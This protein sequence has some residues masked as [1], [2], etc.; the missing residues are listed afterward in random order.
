MSMISK[1]FMDTIIHKYGGL[2]KTIPGLLPNPLGYFLYLTCRCNLKCD[3]CWQRKD[4]LRKPNWHNSC[5]DEMKA[6]DWINVVRNISRPSF[7]CLSGGEA[8]LSTAFAPVLKE[9]ANRRIPV[10]VNT[11]GHALHGKNLDLLFEHGV[12]NISVSLDGFADHHDKCRKKSGLFDSIVENIRELNSR[13]TS[14]SKPSLTIKTVLLDDNCEDLPAFRQFCEQELKAQCLNISFAKEGDHAQVSLKYCSDQAEILT[15]SQ[16]SLHQYSNQ[17]MMTKNLSKLLADNATSSCS[18]A[19]YP[20]M[21]SENEI[22]AALEAK[23]KNV[24]RSCRF[25]WAGV[26]VLPDGQV[27]P[28]LSIALGNVRDHAYS[29]SHVLKQGP[30]SIFLDKIARMGANLP[31]C[32][33][34]CCFLR[35]QGA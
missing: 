8:S 2:R 24:F 34:A 33:T 15:G 17:R 12:K 13:R 5:S 30:Y 28:C 23:G 7:L 14:T 11:N 1:Q 31:D 18:V 4:E 6:E 27:T 10:T 21:N 16:A 35:S 22:A 26:T 19:L 29:I 20:Q 9:A 32:C 25:P 3:Y